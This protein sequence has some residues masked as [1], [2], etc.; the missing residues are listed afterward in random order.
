M[1][2]YNYRDVQGDVAEALCLLLETSDFDIEQ[3]TPYC[4]ELR[5]L[6]EGRRLTAHAASC[7]REITLF[8]DGGIEDIYVD[9]L[10]SEAKKTVYRPDGEVTEAVAPWSSATGFSSFEVLRTATK[11]TERYA[12]AWSKYDDIF[13]QAD[14]SAQYQKGAPNVISVTDDRKQARRGA[15]VRMIYSPDA[16]KQ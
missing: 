15:F 13:H 14:T 16:P 5:D 6:E 2:P 12:A 1:S 11:Q 9:V 7:F 8:N 10:L 4:V 3:K